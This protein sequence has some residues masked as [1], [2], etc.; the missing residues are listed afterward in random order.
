MN[1]SPSLAKRLR[2]ASLAAVL[3]MLALC[4]L[5][6]P[7]SASGVFK[8]VPNGPISGTLN[9]PTDIM[10]PVGCGSRDVT[11]LPADSPDGSS[12]LVAF[13]TV[14]DCSG[15]VVSFHGNGVELAPST[16]QIDADRTAASLHLSRPLY[17]LLSSN[18]PPPQVSTLDINLQ[19]TGVGKL[20]PPEMIRY[21]LGKTD[22]G[23]GIIVN[24][25][26]VGCR[27]ATLAG[28][29]SEDGGATNYLTGATVHTQLCKQLP[30]SL[31]VFVFPQK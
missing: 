12:F 24:L 11:I 4:V 13:V 10:S 3:A 25:N 23:D 22:E 9:A 19:L 16:F 8:G 2:P 6:S 30:G 21:Q 17:D 18:D 28:T 7:A 14:S 20:L 1:P 15:N 31:F 29:V 26:H 27:N 5:A